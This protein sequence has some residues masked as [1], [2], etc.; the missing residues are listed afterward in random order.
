[1]LGDSQDTPEI[2]RPTPD[3]AAVGEYTMWDERMSVTRIQVAPKETIDYVF[4]GTSAA[5]VVD[6]TIT[7]TIAGA[8]TGAGQD[9]TLGGTESVLHAGD[10]TP[11]AI[12]GSG[13]LYIAQYV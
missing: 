9:Y 11:V 8:V 2:Q 3:N 7:I 1:M 5:L 12:T 13:E 10:P 6:G 4:E